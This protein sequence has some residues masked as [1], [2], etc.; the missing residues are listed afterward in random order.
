MHRAPRA[1]EKTD[2]VAL[3][4]YNKQDFIVVGIYGVLPTNTLALSACP[5]LTP[6]ALNS[7]CKWVL[8]YISDSRDLYLV[9]GMLAYGSYST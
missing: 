4:Q 6:F 2:S 5:Y 7:G 8:L 3:L 1:A 9:S